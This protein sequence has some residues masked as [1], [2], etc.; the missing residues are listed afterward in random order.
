LAKHSLRRVFFGAGL[1][2]ALS[3]SSCANL[4][5]YVWVASYQDPHPPA[6]TPAY[7]LG[8]GDVV[9]VRVYN[10]EGMSAK[11]K[12]RSDGKISLPFLNDVQAEGYTPNVLAEQLEARLKD[13]VNKPIIT[14]SVEEQR[15][16]QVAVVGEVGKQG[17][18]DLSADAGVLQ[19]L[20]TAGGLNELAHSDRIFVIRYEN[21]QP[22]RIRFAYK[23]LLHAVPPASTFRLRSG[24]QIAV[25]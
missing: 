4:G 5:Q 2:A 21:G 18:L 23:D 20:A 14:V 12:V 13:F 6:A 11:T 8:A 15:H 10:Q 3:L 22:A 17:V 25:E 19:A 16:I 24:D 7:V 9:Y 1:V